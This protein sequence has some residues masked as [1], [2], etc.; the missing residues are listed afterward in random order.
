[1]YFIFTLTFHILYVFTYILHIAFLCIC[2]QSIQSYPKLDNQSLA[3]LDT[4]LSESKFCIDSFLLCCPIHP[5]KKMIF[6]AKKSKK[7]KKIIFGYQFCQ[8]FN[9][10]LLNS[11]LIVQFL[12][13]KMGTHQTNFDFHQTNSDKFAKNDPKPS[14][15]LQKSQLLPHCCHH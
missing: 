9:Q 3:M 8:N 14:C 11:L 15:F 10:F 5:T 2:D 4:K 12:V 1:M 13:Q 6:G 7:T